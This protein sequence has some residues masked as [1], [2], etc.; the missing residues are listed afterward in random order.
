ML[1]CW[2]MFYVCVCV[3]IYIYI[4]IYIFIY[5]HTHTHTFAY[6][7]TCIYDVLG[8]AK[9]II[10]HTHTQTLTH[11]Y[12]H[13]DTDAYIQTYICTHHRW[14]HKSVAGMV[15]PEI[16][17]IAGKVFTPKVCPPLSTFARFYL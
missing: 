13:T 17:P 11:I 12:K 8:L 16:V 3:C 10:T 1:C 4:Y 14:P 9:K 5:I 6:V 2:A 7:N 15:K